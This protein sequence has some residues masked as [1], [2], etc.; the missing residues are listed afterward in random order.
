MTE[1]ARAHGA[2]PSPFVMHAYDLRSAFD[3]AL[4]NAIEGCVNET[5]GAL[6]LHVQALTAEDSATRRVFADI[7][8]DEARHAEL[9]RDLATWLDGRLT[10]SE[11]ETVRRA[12]THA[13]NELA[14]GLDETA[15]DGDCEL[16]A[17]GL[18]DT[19]TRRALYAEASLALAQ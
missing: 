14:S 11:R 19:A 7:A 5:F 12:A 10:S 9:S 16:R 8:E 4:D 2:E 15:L 17:L 1:L 18:P 13:W 3:L 6:V